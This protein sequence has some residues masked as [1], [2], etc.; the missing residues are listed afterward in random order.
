MTSGELRLYAEISNDS[1]QSIFLTAV[2]K[3]N[4]MSIN[5]HN[6]HIHEEQTSQNRQKKIF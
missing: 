3:Q 6:L 4:L 2:N 5:K 1:D